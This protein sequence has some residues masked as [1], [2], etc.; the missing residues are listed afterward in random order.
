MEYKHCKNTKAIT[1]KQNGEL[2]IIENDGIREELPE[3]FYTRKILKPLLDW[4]KVTDR[5]NALVCTQNEN[6]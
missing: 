4:M 2:R 3:I 6:L 1:V 5:N